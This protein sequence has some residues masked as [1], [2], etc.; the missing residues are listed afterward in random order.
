[1]TPALARYRIGSQLYAP[2]CSVLS[3]V[4][5]VGMVG[6]NQSRVFKFLLQIIGKVE[7]AFI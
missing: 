5:M 7:N 6:I 4:A 1:M 2:D 3:G